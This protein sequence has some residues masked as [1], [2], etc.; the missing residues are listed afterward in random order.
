[1]KKFIISTVFGL[2][3]VVTASVNAAAVSFD[4]AAIADGD[5][6]YGV[7]G[8]EKGAAS[9]TF[10]KN[11]ISVTATGFKTG[12]PSTPYFAYLDSGTAGLGVCKSLT[13]S[14][15]CTPAG[16]DNVTFEESLKLVFDKEVTITETTFLNGGHVSN[17]ASNVFDLSIDGG[18][19]TTIALANI[20]S[21]QFTGT[22]F[23]F[24][25]PNNGQSNAKQFYISNLDVAPV[26]VPA[27]VW[28]FGTGLLGL[29]RF[30][31][32]TA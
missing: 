25:N 32:K 5:S 12:D 16:D 8:G 13:G 30:T 1:M 28:L 2:G 9:F 20:V 21:T 27:A 7:P 6:S 3:M 19:A 29:V 18:A 14:Q 31:R 24:S 4:F 23:I 15:Q 10:T 22:E 26:P 11:G 17:F